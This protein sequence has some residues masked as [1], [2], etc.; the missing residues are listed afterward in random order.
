MHKAV[1]TAFGGR[2]GDFGGGGATD[3]WGSFVS[4][5]SAASST[6]F[7]NASS[8]GPGGGGFDLGDD[9][10]VL[11]ALAAF[12]LVI[13]GAGVY[14]VWAAPSILSEAA[15]QALLAAGLIRASSKITQR[16]WMGS[17]FRSTCV[18]FLIVLLTAGILGSVA[19]KHYPHATRLADIFKPANPERR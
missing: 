13:C 15:F 6:T 5:K 19:Q 8:G 4:Q 9:A 16:D 3:E 2:G 11:I 1:D 14:L 12:A 10:I 17:V 7:R 18:P